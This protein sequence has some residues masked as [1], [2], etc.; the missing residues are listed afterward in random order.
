MKKRNPGKEQNEVGK[1]IQADMGV[2]KMS[3]GHGH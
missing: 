3:Y 1:V 2:H